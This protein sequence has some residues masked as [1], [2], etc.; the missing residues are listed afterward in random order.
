[1]KESELNALRIVQNKKERPV[2]LLLGGHG[3]GASVI[4]VGYRKHSTNKNKGVLTNET[5]RTK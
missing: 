1:M 2:E 5:S 3:T 4:T